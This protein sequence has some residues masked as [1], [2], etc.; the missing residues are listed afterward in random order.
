MIGTCT[1]DSI[2]D[3]NWSLFSVHDKDNFCFIYLRS[4]YE[5]KIP[6][7][8]GTTEHFIIKCGGCVWNV[9]EHSLTTAETGY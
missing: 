4:S 5:Q 6:S 3:L 8:Q 2:L 7:F 1:Y 9:K